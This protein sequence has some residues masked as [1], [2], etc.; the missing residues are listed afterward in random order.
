M[1]KNDSK[2]HIHKQL[3]IKKI[4]F[5]H[6]HSLMF[7]VADLAIIALLEVYFKI[8]IVSHYSPIL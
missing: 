2:S 4:L 6:Y 1:T 8:V 7:A 3:I 5:S